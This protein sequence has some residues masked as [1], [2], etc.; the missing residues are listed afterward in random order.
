[1]QRLLL[2]LTALLSLSASAQYT[3]SAGQN[4]PAAAYVQDVN[5]ETGK[6]ELRRD[7]SR[8]AVV[9]KDNHGNARGNQYDLA[10]D[11]A[12][13]GQTVLVLNPIGYGLSNMRAALR[14]KGL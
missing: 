11:G 4:T 12:F 8:A 7:D 2:A 6:V 10:V 13:D 14:E 3:P 9:T 5:K 1:M